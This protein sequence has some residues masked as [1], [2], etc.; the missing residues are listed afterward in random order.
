M[1]VTS[2]FA[3]QGMTCGACTAAINSAVEGVAGVKSVAVSLIT[4]RASVVHD[5]EVVSPEQI[6]EAID[7][8]GFTAQLLSSQADEPASE[9]SDTA[10]ITTKQRSETIYIKVFGMT[11]SNCS[12]TVERALRSVLGVQEA[13]VAL[14]TEEA[15]VKYDPS[16]VGVRDLVDAINDTGFDALLPDMMDNTTQIQSL[17]RTKEIQN[18]R[19]AALQASCLAIPIFILNMV[20]PYWFRKYDFGRWTFIVPGLH[21]R[22]LLSFA[23]ATPVQFVIG[24][25]FFVSAYKSLKHGSPTMDVLVSLSTFTAYIFSCFSMLVSIATASEMPPHTVFETSAMIIAY[26]TYGKYLENRAKGQTSAALSRLLSLTPSMATIYADPKNVA[27]NAAEREIPSELIQAGDIAILRPGAKAPADGIVVSGDSYMDESLV[28]GEP[29]PVEK[30]IGSA[31]IGGTINGVGRLDFHVTRAGKDTQLS[32]IVNLVQDAQTTRAPIQRFADLVA[33]KFVPIVIILAVV[34]FAVWMVLSHVLSTP[35]DIFESS[36]SKFMV[37][38]KLCISVIVVACPCALGLSTPTAVMVGT[39]IGAQNGILIKGGP[40]LEQATLITKMVFDKTGTL[41]IGKMSVLSHSKTPLWESSAYRQKLWWRIVRAV[42]GGSEHPI[43]K[44]IV[45]EANLVLGEND[46]ESTSKDQSDELQ[47]S[48]YETVMGRGIRAIVQH[49]TEPYTVAVGNV[50]FMTDNDIDV[51]SS[52]LKASTETTATDICVAIQR[53]FAGA[54]SLNDI[55]RKDARGTILALE[56]MGINV[57]MVTGDQRPAALRVAREVGIPESE[58]WSGVTPSEKQDIIRAM[59]IESPD[60]VIAM[61]GDGINDSPAL[62][63]A[64]I[65]LAMATGTDV[66]IEAADIVLMRPDTLLMDVAVSLSLCRAIFNR[67][68]TNL[69]WATIYNFVMIPFAMG[70]FLPLGW[71]LPPMAAGGAMALSSVSVVASSLALKRWKRPRWATEEGRLDL[72]SSSRFSYRWNFFRREP[73][74]DTGD[75]LPLSHNGY[76]Q[77][78]GTD[79]V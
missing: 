74:T 73:V 32:Q 35:P 55:I 72:D 38:L 47:T 14:A 37:C 1:T 3:V 78:S 27:V 50:Q 68:K 76:A 66:A 15:K 30:H 79:A 52:I 20:L 49:G 56:K 65:G 44:A 48:N 63:T 59:Q 34:T 21:V 36:E 16:Q 29:M 18:W 7:D 54:I 28:T 43:G 12:T 51:P 45:A 9:V 57:A 46:S 13:L 17:A 22:E 24:K 75:N 60:A 61:V 53:T 71:S 19:R 77:L 70:V 69:I 23:L 6:R 10:D 5:V 11:C 4:E 25:R 67:I 8:C 33:G 64:H 40:V 26:I 58:V 31:I 39:G 42:E 62:A 41:T 2:V